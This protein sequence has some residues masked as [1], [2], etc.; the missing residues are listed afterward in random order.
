MYEALRG[1]EGG[2]VGGESLQA[3]VERGAVYAG[4]R[5]A[6]TGGGKGLEVGGQLVGLGDAMGGKGR[7]GGDTCWGAV[8]RAVCACEGI[9]GPIEA[10]AMA[11]QVDCC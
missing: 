10:E 6:S 4:Y 3:A 11:S 5:W 1:R 2:D 8:S 7:V 9:H